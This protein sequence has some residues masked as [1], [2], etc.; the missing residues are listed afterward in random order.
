MCGPERPW[1]LGTGWTV[2]HKKHACARRGVPVG[3]NLNI[4][5]FVGH[6]IAKRLCPNVLTLSVWLRV[7]ARRKSTGWLASVRWNVGNV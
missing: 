1:G 5:T 2:A 6:L 3:T 4:I 7:E